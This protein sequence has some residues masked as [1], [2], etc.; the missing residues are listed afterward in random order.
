MVSYRIIS[1]RHEDYFQYKKL[2]K[3]LYIIQRKGFFELTIFFLWYCSRFALIIGY[4][5]LIIGLFS[6]KS[7][8]I[9]LLVFSTLGGM[10]GLL[11]FHSEIR[12][13]TPFF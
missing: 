11:L 7:K 4:I 6:Q 2:H 8:E 12:Y 13:I 5:G 1:D 10:I 3:F 9:M